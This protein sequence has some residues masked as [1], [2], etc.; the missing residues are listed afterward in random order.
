[1][2]EEMT[3]DGIRPYRRTQIEPPRREAGKKPVGDCPR[4]DGI[5]RESST[6]QNVGVGN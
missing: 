4:I 1:M 3:E 6:P 5:A 2:V